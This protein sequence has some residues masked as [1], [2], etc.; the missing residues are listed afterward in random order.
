MSVTLRRFSWATEKKHVAVWVG[1]LEARRPYGLL[2]DAF[3]SYRPVLIG[4]AGLDVAVA[5]VAIAGRIK[6]A[7]LQV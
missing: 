3:G 1:D 4:A 5:V 7:V 6:P 2:H